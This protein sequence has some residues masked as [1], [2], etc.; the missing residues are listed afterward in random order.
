MRL[1]DAV[2]LLTGSSQG[3]GGACAKALDA[4]GARVILHGRNPDRIHG[5]ATELG[6]KTLSADL[7]RADAAEELADAA[8]EVYG[9]LDAVVHCAGVGWY[10][11]TPTMSCA[12]IDEVLDVDLRAP[13]RL[14]RAVLPAMLARGTGHVSFIA[15]IAGLTGVAHESVYSAAKS[16]LVTFADALRLELVGTGVG[17]SV[18]SPAAVRTA[19]FEHRGVPY[20]RRFPR[21]I[22]P[23]RVAAAVVRGIERDRANQIVPRWLAI[24]PAVR[25][26]VPPLFRAL[27]A[28][29]G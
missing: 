8:R 29:L 21:P 17:V 19:F 5:V 4:R 27:N 9:R 3:I 23:E 28:R 10:G 25:A 6:A 24:A 16:G 15:S 2:V 12:Q 26:A 18:V 1:T 7:T 14:T 22:G 11:D 20:E 13:L